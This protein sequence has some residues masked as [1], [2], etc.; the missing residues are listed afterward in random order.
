MAAAVLVSAHGA[1]AQD[2]DGGAAGAAVDL[3]APRPSVSAAA[4]RRQ[5]ARPGSLQLSFS[6]FWLAS[7]S[8]GSADANLTSNDARGSAYR[9]FSAS[10]ELGN[11]AGIEGRV[12]YQ[13]TRL[14]AVEG[15]L[16]Y[17]RPTVIVTVSND[18]EGAAGFTAPGETISQFFVDASLV[19]YPMAKGFAGGRGR[20][21]LEAGAGFLRELHG[22]SSATSG[23]SNAQTGQVYHVGGGVKYFFRTRPSGWVRAYGLRFD[24]RV[25]IRNGGFTFGS[26][27]P[28]S[29]AAGAGLVVAF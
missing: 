3:Q 21:F 11:A 16:T 1:R 29:F 27:H 6:G 7:T 9:L 23:Y 12:A 4:A 25:Y 26:S 28:A 2:V 24:G 17:S 22:Q 20:P 8:L 14:F 18:A 10:G 19:A 15:G 13:V 5:P